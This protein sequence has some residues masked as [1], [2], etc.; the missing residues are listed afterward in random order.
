MV[1]VAVPY[2]EYLPHVDAELAT[3][4][5]ESY[6]RA[7]ASMINCAMLNELEEVTHY[8]TLIARRPI[9]NSVWSQRLALCQPTIEDWQRFL[10]V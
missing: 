2:P 1:Q 3:V 4:V 8:S 5:S 9:I 7:Y 6:K 10:Q